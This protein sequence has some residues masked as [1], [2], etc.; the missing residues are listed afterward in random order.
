MTLEQLLAT[1]DQDVTAATDWLTADPEREALSLKLLSIAARGQKALAD[2]PD[3][4]WTTLVSFARIGLRE[5]LIT[6]RERSA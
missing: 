2:A 1:R 6:M 4:V 3:E 5:V